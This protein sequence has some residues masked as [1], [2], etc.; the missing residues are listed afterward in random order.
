[1]RQIEHHI[2][3]QVKQYL[4]WNN[5]EFF[6]VPNGSARHIIIAKKLKAEGVK[7]GVAD[8]FICLGNEKFHGLFIEVKAPKGYQSPN[9]KEFE[10]RV[11]KLGYEYKIVR[12][13]D[14]LIQVLKEYESHKPTKYRDGFIDGQLNSQ[15]TKI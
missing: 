11:K 1:M 2:Q 4:D 9:Q 7:S 14:D 10:I 3:I 15:I 12:S 5:Y 13:V 6:A 8:I